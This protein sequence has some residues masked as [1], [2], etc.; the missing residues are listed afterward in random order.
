M[1]GLRLVAIALILICTSGLS[2]AAAIP[3][4][5]TIEG[6]TISEW[7]AEWWKWALS[8]PTENNPMLDPD[9]RFASLGNT[10][11]PI[12]FL[13][14]N[15]GASAH[16]TRTFAVPSDKFILFPMINGIIA[17]EGPAAD[18]RPRLAAFI[19]NTTE[20]H[21]SVD[22]VDIPDRFSHRELSPEFTITLPEN[23]VFDSPAFDVPAGDYGQSFSD[24]YWIMLEPLGPGN[25]VINFGGSSTGGLPDDPSFENPF[26]L[27]VT[28]VVP[29]PGSFAL[30]A[31]AGAAIAFL[32][33]KRRRIK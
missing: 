8:F 16:V 32:F 11:G 24:G 30:T 28:Y 3:A 2:H 6:M 29:E 12:F 21:A 17:D 27:D 13:A 18:V 31:S 20:L 15:F 14:G 26:S 33:S 19:D 7:T 5:S 10:G 4:G 1:F 9:G 23:N 25:H 22:G